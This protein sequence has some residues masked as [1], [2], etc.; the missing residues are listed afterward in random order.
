ML[1]CF[2]VPEV[3]LLLAAHWNKM[4]QPSMPTTRKIKSKNGSKKYG[5]TK[6]GKMAFEIR[7]IDIVTYSIYPFLKRKMKRNKDVISLIKIRI[8]IPCL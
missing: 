6:I 2:H 5:E 1:V 3:D 8:F 4:C 7:K